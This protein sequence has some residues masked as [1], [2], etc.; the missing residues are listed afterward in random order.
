MFNRYNYTM[1]VTSNIR[2]NKEPFIKPAQCCSMATNDW[3]DLKLS[4]R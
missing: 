3:W 2:Y 1:F 4:V